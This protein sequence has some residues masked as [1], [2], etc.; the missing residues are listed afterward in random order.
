[1]NY[2]SPISPQR[3]HQ[4]QAQMIALIRRLVELE[5]PTGNKQA[6]DRLGALIAGEFARRGGK[7]RFHRQREAGNVLQVN[8]AGPRG[9]KPLL[10]LGH[11]DTVWELDTLAAMPWRQTRGRLFGPG[12]FDMKAG[13]AIALF[14]LDALR[15]T[16]YELSRPLIVLLNTDEETGSQ[17]SRDIILRVARQCA[18]VLV[19]EPAAGPEGAV[20]TSR[21][22]VGRYQLTVRGVAAHA[23]LDFE[24]GQSAVL[25]LAHQIEKI[26]AFTDLRRGTT[27][28]IGVIRGGARSNVVAAQAGAEIDVRI[29]HA[30]EA[31]VLERKFLSLRPRNQRC[32]L[33][34]RGGI[35][36]MP[37]ERTAGVIALYKLA[38]Q[39]AHRL[40]FELGEAGVGG[41]SDGNFTAAL[42]IPTLD[43][44]GA[45]GEGAHAAHES[46]IISELPRRVALL[47]SLIRAI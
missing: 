30:R 43:G 12:V 11:L 40:G 3:A 36:R 37:L 20:K 6:V 45:V 32:T 8:F 10:L 42:G 17:A 16:G 22:G 19:L 21:K 34:I 31:S 33:E 2:R 27:V 24:K 38:R 18:A 14:A 29:A 28:N 47:A 9:A 1:M 39:A 41:A 46:V 23:G 13:I 7:I 35:N 26:S 25:E 15:D 5:S 44:L 4:R